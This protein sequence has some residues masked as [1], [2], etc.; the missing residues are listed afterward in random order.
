M[1]EIVKRIKAGACIGTV[2]ANESSTGK[3]YT[4]SLQ[5]VYKAKEGDFRYTPSLNAKDLPQAIL[6]LC[7]AYHD[8]ALK[9]DATGEPA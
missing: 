7:R 5:R 6:V 1:G 4:V 8:L 2:F 3:Q 9:S